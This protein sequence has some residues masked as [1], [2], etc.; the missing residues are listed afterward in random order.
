MC[1]AG[2]VKQTSTNGRACSVFGREIRRTRSWGTPGAN[3]HDREDQNGRKA[4]ARTRQ[5]AYPSWLG[6]S[7]RVPPATV[8][9]LYP[10]KT[11]TRH[12]VAT[13]SLRPTLQGY[14]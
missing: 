1:A 10:G 6:V 12:G 14:A 13:V 11:L 8:N 7:R 2:G 9:V 3:L 5:S 4:P